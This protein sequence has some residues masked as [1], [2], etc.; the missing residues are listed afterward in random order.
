MVEQKLFQLN[1][2]PSFFNEIPDRVFHEG[3]NS[4]RKLVAEQNLRSI[5]QQS[6][7][8]T[9]H[10]AKENEST[11]KNSV[12]ELICEVLT[13]NLEFIPESGTSS[14][15][16]SKFKLLKQFL[17]GVGR[18]ST[19]LSAGLGIRQFKIGLLLFISLNIKKFKPSLWDPKSF[20]VKPSTNPKEKCKSAIE[21][22]ISL[23]ILTLMKNQDV[24]A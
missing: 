19:K 16:D 14:E 6:I 21:K 24:T 3:I 22:F 20:E 10:I 8:V 18:E 12:H 17:K 23:D 5:E 13:A 9:N 15:I 11:A 4:R 2:L 7:R 1:N